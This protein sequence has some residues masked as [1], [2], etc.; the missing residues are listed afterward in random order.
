MIQFKTSFLKLGRY[1]REPKGMREK[2]QWW[3]ILNDSYLYNTKKK[4]YNKI[5]SH[6]YN[7]RWRDIF[8]S[9][10]RYLTK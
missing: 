2:R 1:A 4:K 10:R 6:Y 3:F 5:M 8:H 9:K 7:D